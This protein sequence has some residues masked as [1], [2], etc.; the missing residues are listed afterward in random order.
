VDHVHA[1]T[2]GVSR[3]RQRPDYCAVVATAALPAREVVVEED[4]LSLAVEGDD[5]R[6]A[7][8]ALLHCP[9]QFTTLH[10][11]DSVDG[12]ARDDD[13]AVLVKL[14]LSQV[15]RNSFNVDGT[16]CV[17]DFICRI[18]HRSVVVSACVACVA[19]CVAAVSTHCLRR[20]V[21]HVAPCTVVPLLR[22]S[23]EP[24]CVMSVVTGGTRCRITTLRP[25]SCGEEVTI[26]Y[27]DP[28][29]Y[30]SC[31]ARRAAL[32]QRYGFEC[33]CPRCVREAGVHCRDDADGGAAEPGTG[34][35]CG[36]CV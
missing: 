30:E 19:F 36:V 5:Y 22:G 34:A 9:L 2:R 17:F 32:L 35:R 21:L 20:P 24:N 26:A 12:V 13:A 4:G 28:G 14:K 7:V 8:H 10:C 1:I 29:D 25:L 16:A 11:D 18:N 27:I 31:A 6:S 23:C 33:Q 15:R 3:V